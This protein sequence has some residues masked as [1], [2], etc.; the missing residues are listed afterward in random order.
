MNFGKYLLLCSFVILI[1]TVSCIQSLKTVEVIYELAR[2]LQDQTV[3]ENVVI[4]PLGATLAL[5]QINQI[6][7]CRFNKLLE[8]A[9]NWNVNGTYFFSSLIYL[10][11][12]FIYFKF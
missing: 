10:F 12:L 2:V 4:S 7:C 1:K 9:M 5:A 3:N 6:S 8:G 11:N